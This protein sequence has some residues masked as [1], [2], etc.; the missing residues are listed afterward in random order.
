M[1][2]TGSGFYPVW[3]YLNYNCGTRVQLSLQERQWIVSLRGVTFVTM[4]YVMHSA[5]T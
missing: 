4:G 2:S 1:I 5:G 3:K